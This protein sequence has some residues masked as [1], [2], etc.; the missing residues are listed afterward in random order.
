MSAVDAVGKAQGRRVRRTRRPRSRLMQAVDQLFRDAVGRRGSRRSSC[1]SRR[2][3]ALRLSRSLTVVGRRLRVGARTW[4]AW[5]S[6]SACSAQI[7]GE[8]RGVAAGLG[9]C[10]GTAPASCAAFVTDGHKHALRLGVVE[11]RLPSHHRAPAPF[12]P[13]TPFISALRAAIGS[14][15]ATTAVDAEAAMAASATNDQTALVT[16][17]WAT[18]RSLWKAATRA[19]EPDCGQHRP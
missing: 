16:I 2:T 10:P 1:R 4:P 3:P 9:I 14:D 17:D 18:P 5:R 15:W 7:F 12:A 11:R 8:R 19:D 13:P 6:K